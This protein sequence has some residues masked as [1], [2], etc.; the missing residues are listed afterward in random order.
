MW[1]SKKAPRNKALKRSRFGERGQSDEMDEERVRRAGPGADGK[2]AGDN[3]D[4][5]KCECTR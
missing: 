1:N 3:Q 2:E 5:I 4:R